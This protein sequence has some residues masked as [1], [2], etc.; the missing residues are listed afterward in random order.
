M[1]KTVYWAAAAFAAV[2]RFFL[3]ESLFWLTWVAFAYLVCDCFY[4]IVQDTLKY[5]REHRDE[6]L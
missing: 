5:M 2:N 4:G 3:P 1:R 6:Q